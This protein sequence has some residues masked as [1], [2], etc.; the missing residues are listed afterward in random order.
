M[1]S[2]RLALPAIVALALAPAAVAHAQ[3]PA[4]PAPPPPRTGWE[5]GVGL[6][7][8]EISCENENGD[9]CDGITEAGGIDLHASYFFRGSLGAYVDVWPMVHTEDRWTFTHNIVTVGVKYRPVPI[10]TLTAGVG[11]AQ[12]RL[13][14]DGVL[15]LQAESHTDVV[16]A[17]M[18][19]AGIEVVR[20]RK[21]A[22]ELQ[23][24]VGVGFYS[25]DDNGNGEPD[26]KGRNIGLGAAISWF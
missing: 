16:S 21:F 17:V 10:L 7:G 26:I 2:L 3:T 12:A 1:R 19:A 13:R 6:Y 8:G 24:R 23:G 9:F 11:S 5:L 25:E 14:Y 22:V 18:F 20:G 15:G 4:A